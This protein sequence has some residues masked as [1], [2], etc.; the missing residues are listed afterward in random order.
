MARRVFLGF[1]VAVM[2]GCSRPAAE[3][4]RAHGHTANEWVERLRSPDVKARRKAVAELA[5]LGA[6]DPAVVPGLATALADRDAGVRDA[7]AIALFNLGPAARDAVPAL[8]VAQRDHDA[9]VRD[10]AA[11]A[12]ARVQ[13]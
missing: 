11:K 10:H 13:Q 8:Q 3:P 6:N 7:A 12:L 5:N 2:A 9:R 1:V 4:V